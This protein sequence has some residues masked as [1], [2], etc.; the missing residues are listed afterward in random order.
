M[1]KCSPEINHLAYTDDTIIFASANEVSL[2]L[3]MNT[4]S[5]YEKDKCSENEQRQ[6]CNLS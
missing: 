3:I 6:D 4:I 5:I 1:P 2:I